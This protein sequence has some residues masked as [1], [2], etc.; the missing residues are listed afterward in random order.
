MTNH[1]IDSASFRTF[2]FQGKALFTLENKEKGTHI[3]FSV[4]RLKKRRNQPEETN[5]FDVSVK[6]VGDKVYGHKYIGRIDRRNRV[7]NALRYIPKDD[8]GILTLNWIIQHW[9]TLEKY[10]NEGKLAM[11]HIGSCCKCGMPLTV[12][13][14]IINGIGPQCMH[15]R[16]D[17]SIKWLKSVGLDHCIAY[18]GKGKVDYNKTVIAAC[19]CNAD[20]I[21]HIFI[22]DS[23][24]REDSWIQKLDSFKQF[25]LF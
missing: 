24:R 8:V 12:P 15:Y 16:E 14:S 18:T 23:V 17:Q 5:Y 11:Y 3:T 2:M 25:G 20:S 10:E 9:E 22:P 1:K 13:E 19:D 21:E 6:A 4:K 7:F